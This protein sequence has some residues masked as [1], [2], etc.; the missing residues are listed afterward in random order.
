MGVFLGGERLGNGN[1]NLNNVE[2]DDIGIADKVSVDKYTATFFGGQGAEEDVLTRIEQLKAQR[3]E[4]ESPYDAALISDRL[5]ALAEG[6][7]KISVGGST[8]FEVK[9]KYHR[10]EDAVNAAR[11]AIAEG[12]IPGGG[13]TLYRIAEKLNSDTLGQLILKKALKSPFQ[14]I[15]TNL[16]MTENTQNLVGKQL[17]EDKESTWDGV[18]D[19]RVKAVEAGVIDPVKVTKTALRNACSI[20][21]LL[22]TCGGSITFVRSKV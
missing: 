1:R 16:G 11:A 8:D 15:Q 2:F 14:Q 22:S 20:A 21:A 19:R 4:A 9:E 18:T 10:I 6:I 12:V 7:A 13:A 17:C 3:A 5:A